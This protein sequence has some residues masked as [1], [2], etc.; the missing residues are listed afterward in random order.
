MFFQ[1]MVEKRKTSR[2]KGCSISVCVCAC[3]DTE[4]CLTC[5]WAIGFGLQ[6][7]K[8][9]SQWSCIMGTRARSS[10]KVAQ[11][12]S[13]PCLISVFSCHIGSGRQKD[14]QPFPEGKLTLI[15]QSQH[16]WL[17]LKKT[18]VFYDMWRDNSSIMIHPS[19]DMFIRVVHIE[20]PHRNHKHTNT[21]H[22]TN[23]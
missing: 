10:A 5:T 21:S 23:M 2:K 4:R 16:F 6:T 22:R 17:L 1:I 9:I 12:A 14:Q 19:T 8:H 3:T 18:S 11:L 7:D 15:F 20:P 13:L